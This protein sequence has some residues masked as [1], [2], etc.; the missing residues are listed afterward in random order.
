[1]AS[2]GRLGPLLG[3]ALAL[4]PLVG[5]GAAGP[6]LSTSRAE[7]PARF[8]P[9]KEPGA[10]PLV[11]KDSAGRV[12]ALAGH[13]G[14]V[15]LVNFWATWCDPCRDEMPSL[16]RLKERLAGRPFAILAVNYGESARK[17]DEFLARM[18]VD[19]QVLLD[20]GQQAA[21]AWRVR[22][23]PASFLV[24]PDGRVRYAVIGELDWASADAE[25]AVRAL[26]P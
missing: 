7:V 4:S 1:M 16:Q 23:L 14:R 24:D 9:W 25:R 21:R 10:P 2:R 3:A 22:V 20:P 17:V 26:L 8:V 19:F 15:V 12:H 13:R 5:I 18:P 6:W 11:L